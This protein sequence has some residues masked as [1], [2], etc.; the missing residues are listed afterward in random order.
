MGANIIIYNSLEKVST[1]KN[2]KKEKEKKLITYIV[3]YRSLLAVELVATSNKE[4]YLN[5]ILEIEVLPEVE[6]KR[7]SK[8]KEIYSISKNITKSDIVKIFGFNFLTDEHI[9]KL[10]NF[11]KDEEFYAYLAAYEEVLKV[12]RLW[13]KL[14]EYR[15]ELLENVSINIESLMEEINNLPAYNNFLSNK[16]DS[17]EDFYNEEID[18]SKISTCIRAMDET[19]AFF[20]KGTVN[21]IMGYTGSYKTLYCTNVAYG[22]LKNKLNVCYIS[23]EISRNEMYYNFLSRYSNEDIFD[24]QLSHTDM[25][26]K[27]LN[28]EDKDYLFHTIIPSFDKELSKHLTIIDENDFDSNSSTRFD[29]IFRM[30]EFNFLES[31]GTGVDL[32]IIDHLNLLKFNEKSGMNDYSKVNNWMTYF[33]KNCKNFISKHKQICI[34]VAVQ[35][36]RDGYDKAKRNNG[37]YSLTAAAE[38]NE[39]ERSSENILAIYSDSDLKSKKRAKLQLIKGRNCGEMGNSIL[40]SVNPKYYIVSDYNKEN[41]ISSDDEMIDVNTITKANKQLHN[42][43]TQ[44]SNIDK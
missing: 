16:L 28:S 33:R 43:T 38:G 23:L 13:I 14:G 34:L 44:K 36:S 3:Y 42:T 9:K 21:A 32:V 2:M 11:D 24:R 4:E 29:E 1:H 27:D 25:K 39:I 20:R 18:K 8:L 41:D 30:V 15:D 10:I 31:T 7:W 26:F 35:S 17:L 22:A 12:Y 19:N 37:N 6:M 40:I 5:K